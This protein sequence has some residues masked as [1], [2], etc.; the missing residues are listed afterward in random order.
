[1]PIF[2]YKCTVCGKKFELLRR[3]PLPKVPCPACKVGVAVKEPSAPA[4]QFKGE[5]WTRKGE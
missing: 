1:M 4:I 3:E 2:E 5:G